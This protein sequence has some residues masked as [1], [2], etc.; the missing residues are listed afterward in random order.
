MNHTVI[1]AQLAK[2]QLGIE[3]TQQEIASLAT[4]VPGDG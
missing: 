2:C 3:Q 1:A 4:A